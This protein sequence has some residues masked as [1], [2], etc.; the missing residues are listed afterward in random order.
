VTAPPAGPNWRDN[1][2]AVAELCD[3][4]ARD[5]HGPQPDPRDIETVDTRGEYL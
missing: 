1:P 5:L 2:D 4:G 3:Q